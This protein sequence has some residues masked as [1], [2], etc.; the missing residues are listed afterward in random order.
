MRSRALVGVRLCVAAEV[1]AAVERLAGGGGHSL[2]HA[3]SSSDPLVHPL[4]RVLAPFNSAGC[5][6]EAHWAAAR[7]LAA[8]GGPL[9]RATAYTAVSVAIFVLAMCAGSLK[10]YRGGSESFK[11]VISSRIVSFI[12]LLYPPEHSDAC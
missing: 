6:A 3:P 10:L 9:H 11:T 8:V 4:A 7:A 5:S 12:L 2:R 1:A